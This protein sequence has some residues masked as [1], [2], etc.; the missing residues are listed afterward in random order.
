MEVHSRPDETMTNL[1]KIEII[2]ALHAG[3]RSASELLIKY[4]GLPDVAVTASMMGA[5]A[6]HLSGNLTAYMVC[7]DAYL[8]YRSPFN[9][10]EGRDSWVNQA[11]AVLKAP[12]S[13]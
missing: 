7:K 2:K 3:K 5:I 9:T 1:E 13:D 8:N 11:I 6:N 12:S 4:G 10:P